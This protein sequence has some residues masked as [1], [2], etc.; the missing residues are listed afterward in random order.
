MFIRFK[1]QREGAERGR[2]LTL[3]QLYKNHSKVHR[4]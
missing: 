4:P 2:I 1:F 3:E